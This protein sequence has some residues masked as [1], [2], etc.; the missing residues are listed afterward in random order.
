MLEF[1]HPVILPGLLI[2]VI[3]AIFALFVTRTRA[4]AQKIYSIYLPMLAA[5][6]AL[7]AASQP[8][9]HVHTSARRIIVALD[10]SPAAIHAPWHD[11]LWLRSFLKTHLPRH[12]HITLV[13]F[14]S[15]PHIV[16]SSLLPADRPTHPLRL[17]APADSPASTKRLL[18]FSGSTPCWIF[19]TGLL[20]WQWPGATALPETSVAVTVI[21]P[22][23]TDV[24]ITN[25][26]WTYSQRIT[27]QPAGHPP[28]TAPPQLQVTLRSTGPAIATL[29][30]HTGSHVLNQT[31]LRFFHAGVKMVI[32]PPL[33]HRV[34]AAD[35]TITVA[36]HSHDPWPGDNQAS[37]LIPTPGRPRVLILTRHTTTDNNTVPGWIAKELPPA[38]FPVSL[39]FPAHYRA[40]VLDNIPIQDLSSRA[41]KII[42]DYVTKTDGGLLITGT[43]HA[44]GPGGYAWPNGTTGAAS[45]LEQLSPLSC[46][47]PKPKP[48]HIM[49][50]MDVSGSLGNSTASGVT[51]FALAAHAVCSAAQLLKPEDRITVLLFSGRT[52]LLVDGNA[53]AVRRVLPRLLAKIVPNGPTRPNSALPVLPSLLT[54]KAVL[55]MITDGRIPHLNV[56]AWKSML[57]KNAV[58]FAVIAPGHSSRATKQLIAQTQALRISMH[59]FSQWGPLLRA[60]VARQVD[61]T[62]ETTHISWF[63]IPLRLRGQTDRWDRVYV[64]HGA[65]LLAQSTLYPLAAIWRRGLGRVGAIAFADGGETAGILHSDILNMIKMPQGN[66]NFYITADHGNARWHIQAQA[67][68]N[69]TYLNGRQLRLTVIQPHG[70]TLVIPMSQIAPGQYCARLPKRIGTFSATVWQHTGQGN[71]RREDFVGD[72]RAPQLPNH[73]F[74]AT[75]RIEQCPWPNATVITVN[76]SSQT[77]WHPM[78]GDDAF[79]LTSVLWALSALSAMAAIVAANMRY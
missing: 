16:A 62:P 36:L 63:S 28:I 10:D 78:T 50:L 74:P 33:I 17:M 2:I 6:F 66:H 65:T 39:S 64:K 42:T 14:A 3:G 43:Q 54:R 61:G 15:R 48:Q 13:T 19:T 57:I 30:V 53:K 23:Q 60:T 73:Y 35:R 71:Q 21:P 20:R 37:I 46:V 4:T 41:E 40:V 27:A 34:M 5:I 70:K 26:N 47:P 45:V 52:R 38:Q 72:I 29:I 18:Q 24:G 69:E 31:P 77:I 51:R 44:F 25:L 22:T 1:Q 76:S 79:A 7:L 68:T 8:T 55:I 49:F 9:I 12:V 58:R 67:V 59:H 11:P 32:L 75:G 56:P